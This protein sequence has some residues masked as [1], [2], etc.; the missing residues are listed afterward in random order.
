MMKTTVYIR[1]FL[2]AALLCMQ[3][4]A[5]YGQLM[6]FEGSRSR[7]QLRFEFVHNL[8]VI[9]MKVDGKGPYNFILDTGV[10]PLIITDPALVASL[11]SGGF[12]SFRIRGRG[13][14]P[15]L[16]AYVI[17]HLTIEVGKHGRGVLSAVLLKHDP[18]GLSAYVGMPVHGLIGS[19]FF[20]SYQVRIDYGGKR[21]R[22]YSPEAKFRKR[23]S[24]I[25]LTLIRDKPYIPVA[26]RKGDRVDS[27]L[28][29]VDSGAG[30]AVSLD[31][32]EGDQ[33][34]F[35]DST[36]SANLGM[37]LGGPISGQIGRFPEVRLGEFRFRNIIAAYP[38]YNDQQLHLIM[39]ENPGSI[40]GELLKRF[41]VTFDYSRKEM[42]LRKN[43]HFREPF[44][45]DMSGMEIYHP[46]EG[47]KRF[48]IS[49][50]E[51]GSPAERAGFRVDDEILSI[52]FEPVQ[53]YTLQKINQ[54]LQ[55][56][57]QGQLIFEVERNDDILFKMITLRRR[58]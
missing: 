29:L 16:E 19:D 36:I 5:G 7:G 17:N 11:H 20:R 31:L 37:G 42:Y 48:F 44:E 33:H 41:T 12:P 57:S 47:E 30:H 15:E 4:L 46:D 32:K 8:T 13:V 1:L 50:I 45:H 58:I 39:T 18:F 43:K 55:K 56:E 6:T 53:R 54:L 27:L 25:G 34:L 24:R 35:P 40:G 28:L 49:R 14:G 3:S 9:E 21:L 52:N 2:F 10:G 23:G 26:F 51:P 38:H 22:F